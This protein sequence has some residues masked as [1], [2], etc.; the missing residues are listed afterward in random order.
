MSFPMATTRKPYE[1]PRLANAGA[2]VL[3]TAIT[4]S[5]LQ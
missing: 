1:K 4:A 5:S 3:S 2:L